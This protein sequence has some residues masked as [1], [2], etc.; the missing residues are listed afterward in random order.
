MALGCDSVAKHPAVWVRMTS[1]HE[2]RAARTAKELS[3]TGFARLDGTMAST[4]LFELP[5]I[6]GVTLF[7]D[8]SGGFPILRVTA[9]RAF[10]TLATMQRLH[11]A[12]GDLGA[13]I[14]V[15]AQ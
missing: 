3:P 12:A 14:K 6:P 10:L 1:I 13:G 8:E 4:G 2:F 5:T 11:D 9:P 7:L 15:T